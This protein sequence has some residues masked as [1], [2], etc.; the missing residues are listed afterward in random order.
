MVKLSPT[1]KDQ[2]PF[3]FVGGNFRFGF[4][5]GFWGTKTVMVNKGLLWVPLSFGRNYAPKAPNKPF[6]LRNK[7]TLVKGIKGLNGKKPL[8]SQG[9]WNR[10]NGNWKLNLNSKEP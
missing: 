8:I 3:P 1:T 6:W 7:R 9:S 5:I 2:A 10:E 4:A